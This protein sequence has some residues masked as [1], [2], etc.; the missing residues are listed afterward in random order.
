MTHKSIFDIATEG[1]HEI[2]PDWMPATKIRPII[3][4]DPAVIWLE[5]HGDKYGFRKEGTPYDFLPFIGEKGRQF[6]EKWRQEITP[7]AMVICDKDYEVRSIE[8]VR[9]SFE[10]IKRG[11][12]VIAKPALWWGP[13]KVYGVPDFLMRASWV[14]EKFPD[15]LDKGEK[16]IA[17]PFL[18]EAGISDYYVVLDIKFTTK[19]DMPASF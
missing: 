5:F 2:P 18:K 6:E 19:L 1:N 13:E 7:E 3:F 14:S 12:P 16:E 15:L 11:V 4:E 9:E 8:K 10:L 17:A